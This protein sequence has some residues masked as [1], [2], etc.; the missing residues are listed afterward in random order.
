MLV[1]TSDSMLVVK[2]Q[3]ACTQLE[4]SYI[5]V[6]QCWDQYVYIC[7]MMKFESYSYFSVLCIL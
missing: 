3:Y 1:N 4:D 5:A 6:F 2:S 7:F